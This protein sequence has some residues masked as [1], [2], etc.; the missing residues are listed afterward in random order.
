MEL[1]I[2]D[3]NIFTISAFDLFGYT[4]GPISLK[5][6]GLM[7]L[8]GLLSAWWLAK[9]RAKQTTGWT[10]DQISDVIAQYKQSGKGTS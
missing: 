8:L 4:I 6:Y 9:Y 1:T 2:I 10:T 7:Y 5:W 3:P